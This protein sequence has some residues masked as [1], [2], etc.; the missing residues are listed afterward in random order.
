[1]YTGGQILHTTILLRLAILTN[2]GVFILNHLDSA[3]RSA[4][5]AARRCA[6]PL[7]PSPKAERFN[8]NHQQTSAM[9]SKQRSHNFGASSPLIST[10]FSLRVIICQFLT[11]MS[12]FVAL[13]Y[14]GLLEGPRFSLASA[15][16]TSPRPTTSSEIEIQSDRFTPK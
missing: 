7:Y 1:M 5:G 12:I 13:Y 4:G 8:Q 6:A 11:L 9:M 15:F 10:I 16:T 3:A 2:P 14:T